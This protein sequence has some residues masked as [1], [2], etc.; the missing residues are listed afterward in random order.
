LIAYYLLQLTGDT[1]KTGG[2][3]GWRGETTDGGF[4][5]VFTQELCKRR[6]EGGK[7]GTAF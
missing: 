1:N 7:K 6:E 4:P 2:G 3:R 5:D